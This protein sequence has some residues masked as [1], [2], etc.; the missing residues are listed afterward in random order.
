MSPKGTGF[1]PSPRTTLLKQKNKT[2]QQQVPY[3]GCPTRGS[4]KQGNTRQRQII[5]VPL[6]IPPH[7]VCTSVVPSLF[8]FASSFIN[9]WGTKQIFSSKPVAQIL[10]NILWSLKGQRGVSHVHVFTCLF[11]KQS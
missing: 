11:K 2:T 3:K 1:T 9:I 5:L 6:T 10:K 7:C 4:R 8:I